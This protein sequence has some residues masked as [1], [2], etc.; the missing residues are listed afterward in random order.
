MGNFEG[1]DGCSLVGFIGVE[2]RFLLC[3]FSEFIIRVRFSGSFAFIF[4]AGVMLGGL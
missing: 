1:W 4:T 3:C 2:I